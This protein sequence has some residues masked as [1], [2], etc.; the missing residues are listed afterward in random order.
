MLER[1]GLQRDLE[2]CRGY[3]NLC[4]HV[5]MLTSQ[6]P[7]LTELGQFAFP[8][9]RVERPHNTQEIWLSPQKTI[10]IIVEALILDLQPLQTLPER[11]KPNLKR[12]SLIPSN[13]T[14]CPYEFQH[15]LRKYY[16]TQH[17][18]YNH[19]KLHCLESNLKIFRRA[20]KPKKMI[21]RRKINIQK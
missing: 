12:I 4:S 8:P 18:P 7:K 11:L 6:F 5:H 19:I 16:N 1:S 13:L 14:A 10:A 17:K 2:T 20:K 21:N 15:S 9:D 3:L